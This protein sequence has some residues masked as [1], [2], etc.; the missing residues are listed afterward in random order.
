MARRKEI[1]SATRYT[2]RTA[3]KAAV[4]LFRWAATDHSGM[5]KALDRMP[6]MGLLDTLRY[7]LRQLLFTVV[8]V[9]LTAIVGLVLIFS[10]IPFLITGHF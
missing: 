9:V 1:H 4:G 3:N 5:S 8:G 2:L 7:I 10:V 6:Q